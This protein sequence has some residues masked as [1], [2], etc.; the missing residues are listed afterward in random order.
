MFGKPSFEV[1]RH[2]NVNIVSIYA[3]DGINN[4]NQRTAIIHASTNPACLPP[5]GKPA[6]RFATWASGLQ[7]YEKQTKKPL[8]QGEF[9]LYRYTQVNFFKIQC[10]QCLLG[11]GHGREPPNPDAVQ[12]GGITILAVIG[13]V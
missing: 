9:H 11:F 3:F 1:I 8:F 7:R 2:T 5:V 6:G 4:N 13:N 10:R 12:R